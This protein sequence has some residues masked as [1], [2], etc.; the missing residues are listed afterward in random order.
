MPFAWYCEYMLDPLYDNIEDEYENDLYRKDSS[1]IPKLFYEEYQRS[2][3]G[4]VNY[5]MTE[6][7]DNRNS[8]QIMES[9]ENDDGLIEKLKKIKKKNSEQIE[10]L[11][12]ELNNIK[13]SLSHKW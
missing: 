7:S 11:E 13:E 10:K 3:E 1:D 9:N 4:I 2:H 12:N 5:T 8:N 6:M